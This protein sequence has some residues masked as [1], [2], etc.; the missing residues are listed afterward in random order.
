[1]ATLTTTTTKLL[2]ISLALLSSGSL[3]TTSFIEIPQLQSQPASRS[4]PSIRWYF[5]RGS[6]IFPQAA[7]ISCAGFVYLA[8]QALPPSGSAITQLFKLASNG[9]KVNGY[10]AAAVLVISIAPVTNLIMLPTNFAIIKKNEEKG[11]FRS[12]EAARLSNAKPGSRSAED[13]SNGK[14]E[15]GSQWTDLSGPQEK[16]TLDTTKEEDA[17]VRR[18]LNKFGNLNLLRAFVVGAA[19]L[20]GLWAALL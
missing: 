12:A 3:M 17:E 19:G 18:L 20:V 15:G 16:T 10:L 9:A 4:L 6:H 7:G 13:S 8:Y 11:G 2:S 14:G 1:M 5:S